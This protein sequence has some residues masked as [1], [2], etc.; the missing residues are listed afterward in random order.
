MNEFYIALIIVGTVFLMVSLKPTLRICRKSGNIAW[1]FLF[2][3]IILFIVGY[4]GIA[5]YF[6]SFE[7]SYFVISLVSCILFGG[8]LFVYLVTQLSYSSI[9]EVQHGAEEQRYQAEH[10]ML[11]GLP[12]RK[13]FFNSL[14]HHINNNVPCSVF[15][16]DLN[17]FK[18]INDSFGH[19]YGDQLLILTAQVLQNNL[20]PSVFISRIGGDEFAVIFNHQSKSGFDDCVHSLMDSLQ[21]PL[22]I[23]QQLINVDLSIGVSQFPKDSLKVDE[24][25]RHADL[26]MY[27]AKKSNQNLVFYTP[28]IGLKAD[29]IALMSSNIKIAIEQDDFLLF[30]QPI[31]SGC[32]GKLKGLEAL[33]RWPQLD[34]TFISPCEFIVVAEGTHLILSITKCVIKKATNDLEKLKASGFN[35][36]LNI[37]LSAQDLRSNDFRQF[38]IDLVNKDPSISDKIIFEITES[39]MM[40]NIKEAKE[41]IKALN[42]KGFQFSIDDFGT[43]FS[44]LSLLREL[45]IKQIKIDRSFVGSMLRQKADYAIVKSVIFLADQLNCN[46]VAEG[47]ENSEVEKALIDLNCD[48]LQ[49]FYYSKPM[50][51]EEF[52]K[53]YLSKAV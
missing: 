38:V 36:T 46:V 43:G 37:N 32:T 4:F 2:S 52:E 12:N 14:S 40:T 26:A 23:D 13:M 27:E 31:I 25:V 51:I 45:P 6:V 47:V 44:S 50:P 35:G 17:N 29:G 53:N 9:L 28:A 39:A 42:A 11:T 49:G 48:Y 20:L 15:F 41:T 21:A 22:Q 30:Y 3:F 24:L 16:I 33:I 19:H 10:D 18:Q 1:Y 34:G 5:Y 7:I 8:G